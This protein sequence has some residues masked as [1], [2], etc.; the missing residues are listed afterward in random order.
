MYSNA[1][2][3]SIE[4]LALALFEAVRVPSSDQDVVQRRR[5]RAHR[6]ISTAAD[7]AAAHG[8][9]PLQQKL[10]TLLDEVAH[11]SV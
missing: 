10:Y 8:S 11:Q 7:L 4:E 9:Y 2:S 3:A 6:L 5:M 1:L